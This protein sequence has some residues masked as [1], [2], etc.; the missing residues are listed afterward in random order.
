MKS[1]AVFSGNSLNIKT[2][3]F[4]LLTVSLI[5][6]GF[7]VAGVYFL[8]TIAP[9]DHLLIGLGILF[10]SGTLFFMV[11]TKYYKLHFNE[12]PGYISLVESTS[13]EISPFK[14]PL[15]YFT[16]IL[17]QYT[18]NDKK[19]PEYEI[20]LKNRF[21][22]ML[23]IAKFDNEKEAKKFA[24]KFESKIGLP[25]TCRNEIELDSIN[26]KH[27]FN[28]YP[29][30]LPDNTNVKT[31][32][33]RDTASISWKVK[34]HPFQV[35]FILGI[36]YGFFHILHFSVIPSGDLNAL[37]I[38]VI[39][40]ALGILLSLLITVILFS[41]FGRYYVV[42]GKGE[43]QIYHQVFGRKYNE[44]QMN[45]EDV[46]II[47]STIDPENETIIIASRKGIGALNNLLKNYVHGK[48]NIKKM[49]DI[50][51]VINLRDELFRVDVST[52]RLVEKLYI[53]QFILKNF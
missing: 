22:S 53:D 10:V 39:Y 33:T 35:G 11:N 48:K 40:T 46:A 15:K 42:V 18:I 25:L 52:L 9:F 31:A 17:M 23:L 28:P 8:R 37:A 16:E 1:K 3:I 4:A 12:E 14:I 43:I 32:E 36:Y 50:D 41:F 5:S 38:I 19:K 13:W 47:R 34:Y 6:T 26:R 24:E 51:D 44:Q 20:I 27:P 49:I 45:K 2:P 7:I 21:G 30:F 29:L